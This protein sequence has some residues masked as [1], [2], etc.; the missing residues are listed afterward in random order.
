MHTRLVRRDG[1]VGD[2]RRQV[3]GVG[4]AVLHLVQQRRGELV[5]PVATRPVQKQ[6]RARE[7]LRVADAIHLRT[8]AGRPSSPAEHKGKSDCG[9]VYLANAPDEL[10][11][12]SD[13]GRRD[14]GGAVTGRADE[15][16]ANGS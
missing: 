1:A 9:R 15:A 2:E 4:V 3:E 7:G 6:V 5:L 13:G 14:E 16:I 12:P 8:A 10:D 11:A